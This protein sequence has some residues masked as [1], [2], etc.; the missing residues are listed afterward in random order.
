MK[1]GR[2]N[3]HAFVTACQ[4]HEAVCAELYFVWCYQ[5]LK[6]LFCALFRSVLV[7]AQ[8]CACLQICAFVCLSIS[9]FAYCGML[10]DWQVL[11]FSYLG[12]WGEKK[13]YFTQELGMPL[14]WNAYF[15]IIYKP[16]YQHVSY[17]SVY[18][19]F[20]TNTLKQLLF[21]GFEADGIFVPAREQL[22]PSK[23]YLNN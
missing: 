4:S 19:M 11:S 20:D 8:V 9:E 3:V 17:S 12:I 16:D 5:T 15:N 2:A 22:T 18:L 13:D 1:R 7:Q 21:F 6:T 10:C 23:T 14:K